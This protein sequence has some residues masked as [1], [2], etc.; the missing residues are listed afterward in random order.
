[1][2][3]TDRQVIFIC[4]TR[5][6]Y[7]A[8]NPN[9]DD[10]LAKHIINS[11]RNRLLPGWFANVTILRITNTMVEPMEALVVYS[12]RALSFEADALNAITGALNF[13][14]IHDVY[15]IWGVPFQ[16]SVAD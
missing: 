4:G 9:S 15:H 13:Y 16:H 14:A 11:N 2:F 3:F 10:S 7:E 12:T 8:D 5:I 6:C 1:L